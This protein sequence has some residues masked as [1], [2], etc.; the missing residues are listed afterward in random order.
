M[1]TDYRKRIRSVCPWVAVMAALMSLPS[2]IR[3]QSNADG[4]TASDKTS[5]SYDQIAPV[6]LGKES[7]QDVMAKDKA[8]KGSVMARQ[9]KLLQERYDA[10]EKTALV[11][12]MRQL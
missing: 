9:N 6:L 3:A 1:Q 10:K 4:D 11:A 8:A 7:F 2:T 12:Y 5:S